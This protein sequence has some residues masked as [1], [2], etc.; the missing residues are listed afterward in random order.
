MADID[1][2]KINLAVRDQILGKVEDQVFRTS[3]CSTA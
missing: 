2:D 1:W 3:Y